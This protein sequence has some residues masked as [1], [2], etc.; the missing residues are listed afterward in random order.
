MFITLPYIFRDC[1]N[2]YFLE[3]I[4]Y[5]CLPARIPLNYTCLVFKSPVKELL[6]RT[7]FGAAANY[8][9]AP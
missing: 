2:C 7:S 5:I 6:N 4:A 3:K 1:I 8:L 9:S